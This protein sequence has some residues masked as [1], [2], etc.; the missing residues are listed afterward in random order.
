VIEN[1]RRANPRAPVLRA[2]LALRLDD[3]AAVHGK[4]VLV[5]EDGPTITHGGMPHGAGM[6][7]ARAAGAA[8]IVD[9]RSCAAPSIAAIYAQ[10]PHIGAVLPALGYTP[11]Q[12]EALAATID[13]ADADCVVSATPLDLATLLH[14]VKPVVRVR[15]DY[16][17][18]DTPGLAGELERFLAGLNLS[19]PSPL[20]CINR[21]SRNDY[22]SN[23]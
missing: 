8:S 17:D 18:A 20:T 13:S 10:Y 9:P 21:A 14:T 6:A 11:P 3:P 2:R 7:A 5:V 4:R 1:A 16:E 22:F 19:S 15:Y 23:R 12:L